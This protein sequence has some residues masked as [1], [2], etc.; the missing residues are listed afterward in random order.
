[1]TR[2]LSVAKL[3][4]V[5]GSEMVATLKREGWI[6]ESVK[7]SHHKLV[8]AGKHVVVPVHGKR[9]LKPGTLRKILKEAGLR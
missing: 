1:M 2:N 9:E 7:G 5:T 3:G 6:L 8:K 4:S